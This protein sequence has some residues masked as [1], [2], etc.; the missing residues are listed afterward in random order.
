MK[1]LISRGSLGKNAFGELNGIAYQKKIR[2][3]WED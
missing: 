1:L 3:E 2:E